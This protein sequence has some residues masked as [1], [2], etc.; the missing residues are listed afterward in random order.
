MARALT[1]RVLRPGDPGWDGARQGFG[2]RFD[3]DDH[4]PAAIVFAQNSE[5]VANAVRWVRENNV[6]IR[7][8]SGRHSYQGYS[9]LVKDGLLIDVSEMDTVAV[10]SAEQK[11]TIGAGIDMLHLTEKL[12]D[13]GFIL[14]VATGPTVGLGGLVQGGGFGITSRRFGLMCDCLESIEL[15]NAQGEII[16]ANAERNPDL[17]WALR[18]GG[19]GNFGILTSLRFNVQ[20]VATV[21]V[22]N[23]AWQ[24]SDFA[25]IVKKWQDWSWNSDPAITS[26]L[27]L[28]VDGT[29]RM[30]GQYSPEPQ[31]LPKLGEILLP[32][33]IDPAPIS[34]QAMIVPTLVAA[35][36]TFGVD[37]EK[38]EWAIRT[39][40]NFQL[41]KS[42]S[43]I[44]VDTIPEEGIA[45]M[46]HWLENSP[47]LSAP[48][49]QQS[50]IQLLGGGGKAASIATDA[51][52]VFWR[53]A[54]VVVQYDGYWTAPQD[55]QPTIDWVIN[56]RKAMLPYAHGAYVNYQDDT[57]GP[58]WLDQYY[59]DNLARL[60][61]VKKKYDPENFFN[62][63]QSIPLG[64]AG[65]PQYQSSS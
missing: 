54:K 61:Q 45:V 22:F 46:K 34:I 5:D 44:A 21:G 57:L 24:W 60:Q 37:P 62:F 7:A 10:D 1:G 9:S 31:D 25:A 3:Y 19:G 36:M 55:A 53:N 4:T 65:R 28:H 16:E 14:P 50:M 6:G 11:A 12:A 33:M 30:E 43:A 17:F 13:S 8:R 58:D 64:Y 51:T 23:V 15:V 52:A 59:G 56:M 20:S 39:H 2:A 48:P 49:S 29:V 42:T 38:P 32:L 47:T 18:G 26:M 35:R 41:F 63:P 40:S 27:T